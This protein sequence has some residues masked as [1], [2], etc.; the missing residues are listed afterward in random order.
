MR[1]INE[2]LDAKAVIIIVLACLA[3]IFAI[4][5]LRQYKNI[6]DIAVLI[7]SETEK[8]EDYQAEITEL[9]KK[10]DEE[11]TEGPEEDIFKLMPQ[12]PDEAGLIA[13]IDR[14]CR[15][16]SSSLRDVSFLSRNENPDYL[17]IPFNITIHTDYFSL[18]RFLEGLSASERFIQ[19][20][21]LDINADGDNELL[22]I[23]ISASAFSYAK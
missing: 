13:S 23:G 15:E 19:L 3:M 2:Y 20:T 9:R 22:N 16:T 8:S 21:G 5:C 10:R 18:V 7:D 6:S 11:K 4:L 17:E 1:D 12:V 14:L